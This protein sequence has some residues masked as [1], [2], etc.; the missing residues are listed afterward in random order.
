MATVGVL[1]ATVSAFGII[2]QWI[3][4]FFIGACHGT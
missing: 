1:T 2:L 3:P 4:I